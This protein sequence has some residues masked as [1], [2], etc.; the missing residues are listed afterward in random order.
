MIE[1]ILSASFIFI[2]SAA[3][4]FGFII[5]NIYLDGVLNWIIYLVW[6]SIISFWAGVDI[7]LH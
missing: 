4:P 1:L 5:C 3:S 7:F 6:I 2:I